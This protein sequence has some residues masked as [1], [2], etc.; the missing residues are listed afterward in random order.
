MW[1]SE[2]G[3]LSSKMC[4]NPI[5]FNVCLWLPSLWCDFV[6]GVRLCPV[7]RRPHPEPCVSWSGSTLDTETA[8]GTWVS[9]GRSLWCWGLRRQ[10][11]HKF[12]LLRFTCSVNTNGLSID[13]ISLSV[14]VTTAARCSLSL[15][16]PRP[17]KGNKVLFSVWVV[18]LYVWILTT[19]WKGAQ[20]ALN[21]LI[22]F[23]AI[24]C[25]KCCQG[26]QKT[27]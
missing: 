16:W 7:S 21:H 4:G 22:K 11:C 2:N 15:S 13:N 9:A 14:C 17:R 18:T 8:S 20:W 10:V 25:E 26:N 12:S 1:K 27:S 5:R 3:L 23:W 6:L 19:W 24:I